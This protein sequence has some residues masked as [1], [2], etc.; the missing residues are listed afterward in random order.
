M[1]QPISCRNERS[2]IPALLPRVRPIRLG[3]T[4]S[5][6]YIPLCCVLLPFYRNRQR[7]VGRSST[8]QEVG[9]SHEQSSVP[10]I[11][12]IGPYALSR[13][14][15]STRSIG[16][17]GSKPQR[18]RSC[19]SSLVDHVDMIDLGDYKGRGLVEDVCGKSSSQR[20]RTRESLECSGHYYLLRSTT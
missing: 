10:V 7:R 12:R 3:Q 15:L 20:Q 5:W 11:D 9:R 14:Y 17:S 2:S 16:S 13:P 4:F 19:R 18:K 1:S 6:S 8:H